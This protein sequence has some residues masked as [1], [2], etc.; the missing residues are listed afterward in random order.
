MSKRDTTINRQD[1]NNPRPT[2]QTVFFLSLTHVFCSKHRDVSLCREAEDAV[3]G[4]ARIPSS[5]PPTRSGDS[6]AALTSAAPPPGNTKAGSIGTL[7]PA[8]EAAETIGGGG[9]GGGRNRE[10]HFLF[11]DATGSNIAQA[12]LSAELTL[13]G[14]DTRR[15]GGGG[16]RSRIAGRL[17]RS[18]FSFLRSLGRSWRRRGGADGVGS[19]VDLFAET[20]KAVEVRHRCGDSG[21]LGDDINQSAREQR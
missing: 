18:R 9:G 4:A 16:S 6:T 12:P 20:L 7:V 5:L 15:D 8:I 13:V 11:H 10:H 17:V 1:K 19:A 2:P 3:R 21:R 14:R